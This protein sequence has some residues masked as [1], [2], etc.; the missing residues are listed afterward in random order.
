MQAN[1][2]L[3]KGPHWKIQIKAFKLLW[4][5][6]SGIILICN[7]FSSTMSFKLYTL[8]WCILCTVQ[9]VF[10]YSWWLDTK[11]IYLLLICTS[12]CIYIRVWLQFYSIPYVNI[13]FELAYINTTLKFKN[14]NIVNIYTIICLHINDHAH[15]IKWSCY[16]YNITCTTG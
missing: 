9:Y 8:P 10:L 15:G 7:V 16:S 12:S 1:Y 11:F 4:V 5:N 13:H 14:L 2:T 3:E 6:Y